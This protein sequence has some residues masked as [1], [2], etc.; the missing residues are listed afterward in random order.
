M[1]SEILRILIQTIPGEDGLL[2]FNAL[3]FCGERQEGI[4]RHACRER[5]D[6][7]FHAQLAEQGHIKP[8][9][10]R[11]YPLEQA[12]EAHRYV[13]SGRKRGNGVFLVCE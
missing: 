4:V 5:K 13:D 10:D 12:A 1:N 2:P 7:A 11:R 8:F 3:D 9:I 6:L